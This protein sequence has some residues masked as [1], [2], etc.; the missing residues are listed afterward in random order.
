MQNVAEVNNVMLLFLL[1][2]YIPRKVIFTDKNTRERENQRKT[3]SEKNR[4]KDALFPY[5]ITVQCFQPN[6]VYFRFQT[7]KYM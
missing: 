7:F 1:Q 5:F 4:K 6:T 3:S 2:K